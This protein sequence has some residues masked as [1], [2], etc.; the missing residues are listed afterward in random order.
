MPLLVRLLLSCLLVLVLGA[1][2]ARAAGP[3]DRLPG[4]FQVGM[5]SP[6][7]AAQ[8]EAA[9]APLGLR[10][11]YVTGGVK[12]GRQWAPGTPG[13]VGTTAWLRET[14]AAGAVPVLTYY[15]MQPSARHGKVEKAR[16]SSVLRS[17]SIMRAYWRDVR[18]MLKVAGGDRSQLVVFHIEPD[19][20]QFFEQLRGVKTPAK[21]SATGLRELRGLSNDVRGYAKAFVRL[22]NRY[23]PNVALGFHLSA[24]GTGQVVPASVRNSADVARLRA[25]FVRQ[26]GVKFDVALEDPGG[27][28]LDDASHAEQV[29]LLGT[30]SRATRLPLMLWQTPTDGRVAWFLGQS[31]ASRRHLSDLEGAGVVGMMFDGGTPSA[32]SPGRADFFAETSRAHA[33]GLLG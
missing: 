12:Q 32:P 20:W 18:E 25:R 4:G 9:K 17:R 14:Q 30:F 23:A 24:W 11:L 31:T 7:G 1:A 13:A 29:S 22:R 15:Q 19:G 16:V 2:P 27:P 8:A 6:H 5:F 26:L 10:Y 28:D 33:A 3:L 21:V